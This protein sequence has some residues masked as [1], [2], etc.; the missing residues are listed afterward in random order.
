MLYHS[1][2][3][4]KLVVVMISLLVKLPATTTCLAFPKED[5]V[6]KRPA[7]QLLAPTFHSKVAVAL[8]SSGCCIRRLISLE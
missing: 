6:M 8:N 1:P 7:S 3:F 5:K 2:V 4:G